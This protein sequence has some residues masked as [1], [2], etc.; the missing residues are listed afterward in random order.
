[1][2]G[3]T[4][5]HAADELKTKLTLMEILGGDPFLPTSPGAPLAFNATHRIIFAG[6][7]GP[8]SPPSLAHTAGAHAEYARRSARR[9]WDIGFAVEYK[10][11]HHEPQP[12]GG[13]P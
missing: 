12:Y 5:R 7:R 8:D 10:L 13:A 9:F 11:T 2:R 3:P 1:V 4:F 6:G